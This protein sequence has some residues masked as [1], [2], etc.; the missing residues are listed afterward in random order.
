MI[1]ETIADAIAVF[2]MFFTFYVMFTAG[3]IL[4]EPD[5]S[6]LYAP[7]PVEGMR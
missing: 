4:T 6:A 5:Y 3:V 1:R 7:D 2:A